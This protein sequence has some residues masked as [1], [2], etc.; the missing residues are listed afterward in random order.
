MGMSSQSKF[1][2]TLNFSTRGEKRGTLG[3]TFLW[4]FQI[5]RPVKIASTS[6]LFFESKIGRYSSGDTHYAGYAVKGRKL[7]WAPF[8][9][10]SGK[11]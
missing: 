2:Q 3:F 11:N 7:E 6:L 1:K 9:A 4:K 10:C 8:P 5:G